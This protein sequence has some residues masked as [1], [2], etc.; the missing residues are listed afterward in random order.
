MLLER[1][2][3]RQITVAGTLLSVVA[4]IVSVFSPSVDMLIVTYGIIGGTC[5]QHVCNCF[6]RCSNTLETPFIFKLLLVILLYYVKR[7][8]AK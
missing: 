5:V 7:M 1:F 3:C 4:F 8:N 2:T 6:T